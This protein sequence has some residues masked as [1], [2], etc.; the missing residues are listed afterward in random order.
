M[1]KIQFLSLN[2]KNDLEGSKR[3]KKFFFRSGFR[4]TLIGLIHP[5]KLFSYNASWVNPIFNRKGPSHTVWEELLIFRN[6]FEV[7]EKIFGF[8]KDFWLFE[9]QKSF[10]KWFLIFRMSK[11]LFE[12][13]LNFSKRIIRNEFFE[14]LC[15]RLCFCKKRNFAVYY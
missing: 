5:K 9:Y 3:V 2:R 10:S 11:K 4:T 13:I 6:D 7:F 1:E 12:R 15:T 8:R 14:C